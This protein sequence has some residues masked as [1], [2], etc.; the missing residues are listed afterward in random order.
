LIT[1]RLYEILLL[2]LPPTN[3]LIFVTT[4]V[5]SIFR[6]LLAS[7]LF[8]ALKLRPAQ[9]PATVPRETGIPT[10]PSSDNY[11]ECVFQEATVQRTKQMCLKTGNV[12]SWRIGGGGVLSLTKILSKPNYHPRALSNSYPFALSWGD[13]CSGEVAKKVGRS[14]QGAKMIGKSSDAEMRVS[15]ERDA[16]G[17]WHWF[18]GE[19]GRRDKRNLSQNH[20]ANSDSRYK[21]HRN[22][23][24]T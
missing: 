3:S 24:L 22:C 18:H 8:R 14:D 20:S 12:W 10:F 7:Y 4:L 5:Q 13:P 21:L 16:S 6:G 17:C 9:Q 2:P 15:W 1:V 23:L 19:R 11:N